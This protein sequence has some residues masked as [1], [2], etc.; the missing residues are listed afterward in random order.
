MDSIPEKA[1]TDLHKA[2]KLYHDGRLPDAA[3]RL[4]RLLN[5]HPHLHE[6]AFTLGVI[7]FRSGDTAR[8][9][10]LV[11]HAIDLEPKAHHYR[12][13]LGVL[14]DAGEDYAGA[15]AAYREA[16]R[17]KS[18]DPTTWGALGETYRKLG[19]LGKALACLDK[20]V[21]FAPG[22]PEM[23]RQRAGILY[24]LDRI[25][26]ARRAYE[27]VLEAAPDSVATHLSLGM[28]LKGTGDRGGATTAFEAALRLDPDNPTAHF[29][30]AQV[31]PARD[32]DPRPARL[33]A[34]IEKGVGTAVES[35]Q[36]HFA[37]GKLLA[38]TG[39]HDGAAAAYTAANAIRAREKGRAFSIEAFTA[40][41]DAS[42][43]VFDTDFF[44][45]RTLDRPEDLPVLI[46][47]LP[48]SGTTLLERIIGS[49][50]GGY[51][52]G[53]LSAV[54]RL[55]TQ[56]TRNRPG[57]E[58]PIAAREVGP[59]LL[60]RAADAYLAHLREHSAE[61]RRIV[62]KMPGNLTEL[63]LPA[64]MLPRARFV[65]ARRAAPDACV[66]CWTTDFG[67]SHGYRND[68]R[69]LG[70]YYRQC[71]R[72]AEHWRNVLPERILDVQYED[73]VADLEGQTRRILD[74]IGLDWDPAC[75][76]FRRSKHAV[77]T[78]SVVQVRRKIYTSSVGRWRPY[79]EHLAPLIEALG[80]DLM[81]EAEELEAMVRERAASRDNGGT[82]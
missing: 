31:E 82:E 32:G 72:L 57:P 11:R 55:R 37:L 29:H 76:D 63:W 16:L 26:E 21:G 12:M 73:V 69:T 48:R 22:N 41:V 59:E 43:E 56:V 74:F 39:D 4:Q 71:R 14:L 44:A 51:G 50:P 66:S 34:V 9:L 7:A 58:I 13:T 17:I 62:D 6:A 79:A 68:L 46:V 45:Q 38:E 2:M 25:D 36:L 81:T 10:D 42:I 20:A 18:D 64:L 77:R 28:L 1:Q 27:Q 61:A 8:A 60:A 33:A 53:E 65:H 24:D 30:L 19:H 5:K 80:P 47:G 40:Q 54:S 52:A 23:Q 70:L 78:A 35:M 3:D 75:L 49:H 67:G 15:E